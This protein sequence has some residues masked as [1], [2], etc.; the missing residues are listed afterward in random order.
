L[1]QP[2]NVNKEKII[3]SDIVHFDET[4]MS[5]ITAIF[6]G[7]ITGCITFGL[8]DAVMLT[9]SIIGEMVRIKIWG[10]N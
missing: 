9:T 2:V 10:K 6:R 8:T 7:I 1:E 3:N 5:F 4:G